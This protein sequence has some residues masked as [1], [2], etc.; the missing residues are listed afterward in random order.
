LAGTAKEGLMADKSSTLILEALKKALAEPAGLPLHGT[1]KLAGLF[2]ASTSAK[3]AA[4][5]C[6]E[7]G[8]LR[9]LHR[10]SKGKTVQEVCSLT[11]KGLTYVLS[12]VSPKQVLEELVHTLQDR[13]TLVA[14][15]VTVARQ[16]QT[17]LDALQAAVE[18]VLQQIQSGA[19]A[20]PPAALNPAP[21]LNG[22]Q[23][24]TA[25]LLACLSQW[26]ASEAPGDCALPELYRRVLP[27]AH[28]LTIGHYH[29]KLRYLH[30]Q[31]KIYLHPWTG[32]L[33]DIP[34]PAYALLV[35]H[36]IAYYASTRRIRDEG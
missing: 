35:G 7:E 14:E 1:K 20:V 9:V 13:Q 12:Q 30:E 6:L 8:Y 23:T 21:S 31:E 27:T 19:G 16:W 17:G 18:K 26:Q 33:Y 15:L 28:S 11:E 25:D 24:L 29:D 34:E 3:Y 4:Q 32:P 2:T 36:E 10:E 5:H 22:S